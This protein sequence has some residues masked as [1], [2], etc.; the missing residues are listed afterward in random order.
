MSPPSAR[1]TDNKTHNGKRAVEREDSLKSSFKAL[2]NIFFDGMNTGC[3]A[4][5]EQLK[6]RVSMPERQQC[7]HA[8]HTAVVDALRNRDPEQAHDAMR[9][10]LR[11]CHRQSP[12]S[13]VTIRSGG[14]PHHFGNRLQSM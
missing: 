11:Q 4:V 1:K 3:P 9:K 7:Y 6:R 12:R 8:Q 14:R 10:H 5:L 13:R 2:R